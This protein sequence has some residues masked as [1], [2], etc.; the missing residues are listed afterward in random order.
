MREILDILISG[1]FEK[2]R[3]ADNTT[4]VE[5]I[6]H[7][8]EIVNRN[9]CVNDLHDRMNCFGLQFNGC[10]IPDLLVSRQYDRRRRRRRRRRRNRT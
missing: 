1:T 8:I 4:S 9:R 7:A 10:K 3:Y 5:G 2:I 6:R